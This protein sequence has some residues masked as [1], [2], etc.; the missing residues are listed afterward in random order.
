MQRFWHNVS[1]TP[2]LPEQMLANK[3]DLVSSVFGPILLTNDAKHPH[4]PRM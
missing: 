4:S 3:S 1:A 2:V